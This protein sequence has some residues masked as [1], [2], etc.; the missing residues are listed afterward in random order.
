[1]DIKQAQAAVAEDKNRILNSI[2]SRHP[3]AVSRVTGKDLALQPPPSHESYDLVNRALASHFSLSSWFGFM[4]KGHNCQNLMEAISADQGR[5]MVQLSMTGC[6]SFKDSDLQSLV[7]C[8][9]EKLRVLRLDLAFTGRFRRATGGSLEVGS[10][11]HIPVKTLGSN[12]KWWWFIWGFT[13][14]SLGK[15]WGFEP[16]GLKNIK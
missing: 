12:S 9:P 16:R 4:M 8:L 5:Q 15:F 3:D 11:V 7:Q 10:D 1:M 13:I 14:N 6:F 2:V